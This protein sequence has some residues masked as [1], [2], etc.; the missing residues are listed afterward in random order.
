MTRFSRLAMLAAA[1]L[2]MT[3]GPFLTAA[4]ANWWSREGRFYHNY[5][6]SKPKTTYHGPTYTYLEL[7]RHLMVKG[8]TVKY[9]DLKKLAD[10][11]DGLAA[12]NL[13]KRL[14]KSGSDAT[15]TILHYYTMAAA[16]GLDYAVRPLV[17]VLRKGADGASQASL[18]GAE[19]VLEDAARHGDEVATEA[20]AK[21]YLDG[22]PFGHNPDKA[23]AL[24][25]RMAEAGNGQV[26]FQLAVQ[27]LSSSDASKTDRSKVNDYLKIAAKSDDLGVRTMAENLLRT[28]TAPEDVAQTEASQ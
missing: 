22:K 14:N 6:R 20:L 10:S 19:R 3:A 2:V 27:I 12:Y 13:A 23:K 18:D 8:E 9:E 28:R 25:E 5:H 15:T 17:S 1:T 11:G 24:R 4:Q 7:I 16:K 26:A 21:F